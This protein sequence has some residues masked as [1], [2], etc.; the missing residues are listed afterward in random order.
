AALLCVMRKI[1]LRLLQ[2]YLIA[3]AVL[4]HAVVLYLYS[5][6]P[7]MFWRGAD[8]LQ[9]NDSATPVPKVSAEDDVIQA[10]LTAIAGVWQPDETK[11]QE[12]IWLDG[13]RYTS[14]T[15]AAKQLKDGSHL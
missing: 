3:V 5:Y 6:Q 1:L 14:L 2:L 15:A 10:E 7:A 8:L 9:L 12:G 13:Q 11:V 4:L